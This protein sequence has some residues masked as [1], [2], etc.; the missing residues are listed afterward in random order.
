M[1]RLLLIGDSGTL[2]LRNL[3][4]EFVYTGV[5]TALDYGKQLEQ[6]LSALTKFFK[7][8]LPDARYAVIS[9]GGLDI[10]AHWWKHIPET[11][12]SPEDYT[13]KPVEDFYHA[14]K[15]TADLYGLEKIVVWGTPPAIHDVKFVPQYPYYGSAVTRNIMK[16]IFS[17]SF[18][19]YIDGDIG[20]T[21][22][23]YAS[24]FYD[25]VLPDYQATSAVP[26][27][28]GVHYSHTVT[29]LLWDTIN[30]VIFGDLKNY[31][32]SLFDSMQK[33]QF[34]IQT[35]TVDRT[36]LYNTWV[37]AEHVKNPRRYPRKV[38]LLGAD[39]HLLNN[40]DTKNAVPRYTELCL[41]IM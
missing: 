28:D 20:E 12:I 32:G 19:D 39:Y 34:K 17:R 25:Y 35:A 3:A 22:I 15:K 10:R 14:L 21:R 36:I 30:P 9:L 4:P 41:G 5:S 11:S 27:G 38:S 1:S 26:L 33:D 18:I 29:D 37:L 40:T 16:H 6:P 7:Y 8:H 13:Q 2:A 31:T 24:R 23:G